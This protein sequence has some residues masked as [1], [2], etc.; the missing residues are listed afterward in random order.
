[1]ARLDPPSAAPRCDRTGAAVLAVVLAAG[2]GLRALASWTPDCIPGADGAY[3]Y[4]QV[5]GLLRGQGLPFPD[6]PL[7]FLLQAGLARILALFM[8][9]HAAI[10]VAVRALDTLLPP[11]LAA[12][13]LLLARDFRRG[14]QDRPAFGVAVAGTFAV[15][16][17]HAL[18]T[19]GGML[20][21][22]AALPFSLLYILCLHRAGQARTTQARLAW[23]SAA[24]LCLLG[25]ALTHFS[26]LA[27]DLVF[28]ACLLLLGGRRRLGL[29][30]AMAALLAAAV[31]LV[32]VLDPARAGRLLDV[33]LHPARL[34]GPGRGDF[35][36]SPEGFFGAAL[37]LLG[38]G[39]WIQQR[40]ADPP[41]RQLLGACALTTLALSFPLLRPELDERLAL[42]SFVPGLVPLTFLATRSRAGAALAAP[43]LGLAL[44]HGALALKTLRDTGLLPDA[45][46]ELQALRVALPPGRKVVLVHPML[47]W[48]TAWVL[49]VPFDVSAVRGLE[50]ARRG[51]TLLLLEETGRSAFGPARPTG[52]GPPGRSLRD[53]DRLERVVITTLAEGAWFRLSR[54]QPRTQE[55][56][57]AAGP[58][59]GWVEPDQKPIW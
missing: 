38:L 28:T 39:V 2:I 43:L 54:I 31:G 58:S 19:A 45:H 47:R 16:S 32:Q 59:H 42:V 4:V 30:G 5:R 26:A 18:A 41:L 52:G 48:W 13:L 25:S 22:G 36:W 29:L 40:R 23:A 20:K 51:D 50:A 6:F 17:G 33:L 56:P 21:N 44:L 12:P 57:A 49:E 27:V 9:G 11:L 46:A 35:P 37:G 10:M 55:G 34:F 3:Y 24:G 15:A 53:G 7:L 14:P 8:D 1:M